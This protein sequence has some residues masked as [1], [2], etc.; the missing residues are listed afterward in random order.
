MTITESL[1][2]HHLK[3][4]EAARAAFGQ[5]S[6]W[7]M[8]GDVHVFHNNKKQVIN[9]FTDISIIKLSPTYASAVKNNTSV[10]IIILMKLLSNNL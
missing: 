8:R 4:L 7:T 10:K 1:T 6:V 2:K 5:F 3:L 9:E